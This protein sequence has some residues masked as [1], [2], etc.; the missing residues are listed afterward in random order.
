MSVFLVWKIRKDIEFAVVVIARLK[1][2]W[3][4]LGDWN[5]GVAVI[6]KYFCVKKLYHHD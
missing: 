5:V 3:L 1:A 2:G 4:T 6:E